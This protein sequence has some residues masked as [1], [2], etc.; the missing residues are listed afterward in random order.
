[1]KKS[2]KA[3][4]LS[5][6]ILPGL[7]HMYLREYLR[8]SALLVTSLAALWIMVTRA[9]QQASLVVDQVLSG[10]VA[11]EAEAI[12]QAVSNSTTTADSLIDNISLVV[13][14]AC[15][16]V[17]ILDSYRLGAAQERQDT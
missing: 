3:A 10:D 16:L 14:F 1:M 4:L 12:S 6:L 7:G 15:W 5:G 13:L 9:Y 17:G 8:G 2:L 11:L